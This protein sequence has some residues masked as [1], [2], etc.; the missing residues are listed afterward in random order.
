ML[1]VAEQSES[2]IGAAPHSLTGPLIVAAKMVSPA[3]AAESGGAS[4]VFPVAPSELPVPAAEPRLTG[5]AREN[6]GIPASGSYVELD[7]CG[8]D[9]CPVIIDAVRVV[10]TRRR[11]APVGTA[12]FLHDPGLHDD[13]G[14]IRI[15]NFLVADLDRTPIPVRATPG[16]DASG[17]TIPAALLPRVIPE[18]KAESLYIQ[19]QTASF[20]CDWIAYLDWTAEGRSGSLRVDDHG[21]PFRTAAIRRAAWVSSE[22]AA[23]TWSTF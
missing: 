6:G 23:D 4:W 9:G 10:V 3:S 17:Y 13:R 8:E 2:A 15:P 11:R 1:I 19:A 21:Q 22:P 12:V 18:S 16:L 14:P 5:W 20:D 7:V